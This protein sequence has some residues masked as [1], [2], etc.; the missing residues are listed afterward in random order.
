MDMVAD[1]VQ[2]PILRLSTYK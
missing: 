1:R 2:S